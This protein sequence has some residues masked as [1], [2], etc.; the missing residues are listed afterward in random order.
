MRFNTPWA[1]LLI[2]C[3]IA[4]VSSVYGQ[5]APTTDTSRSGNT[6]IVTNVTPPLTS[7]P[8]AFSFTFRIPDDANVIQ[9]AW[10]YTADGFD[11]FSPVSPVFFEF[12]GPALPQSGGL[13][14]QL[15]Y[16]PE[17]MT[18]IRVSFGMYSTAPAGSVT[19]FMNRVYLRDVGPNL[20]TSPFK[21][22]TAL[23]DFWKFECTD[24]TAPLNTAF[25]KI[26]L[27]LYSYSRP[28]DIATYGGKT[29]QPTDYPTPISTV[30][31]FKIGNTF[32]PKEVSTAKRHPTVFRRMSG[33]WGDHI[34]YN[35]NNGKLFG[36]KLST[37]YNFYNAPGGQ[38][39]LP[40]YPEF[41]ALSET[42]FVVRYADLLNWQFWHLPTIGLGLST[43]VDMHLFAENV[44]GNKRTTW[45]G[46]VNYSTGQK[47]CTWTILEDVRG[48]LHG[49]TSG[50]HQVR[51]FFRIPSSLT[52]GGITA[53]YNVYYPMFFEN[54]PRATDNDYTPTPQNA[55]YFFNNVQLTPYAKFVRFSGDQALPYCNKYDGNLSCTSPN[56]DWATSRSTF[57]LLKQCKELNAGYYLVEG[58]AVLRNVEG[59]TPTF[60][61]EGETP[62]DCLSAHH[63]FLDAPLY[64]AT[65]Q[66]VLYSPIYAEN[67]TRVTHYNIH[68][69]V[70]TNP[71]SDN[72]INI[73]V[74]V[75]GILGKYLNSTI[76]KPQQ[77]YAHIDVVMSWIVPDQMAPGVSLLQSHSLSSAASIKFHTSGNNAQPI[78]HPYVTVA[79]DL[80]VLYGFFDYLDLDRRPAPGDVYS[81]SLT[82]FGSDLPY[83][84]QINVNDTCAGCTCDAD[85][86][87]TLND[88]RTGCDCRENLGPIFAADGVTID[89]CEPCL[90]HRRGGRGQCNWDGDAFLPYRCDC[91]AAATLGAFT[92]FDGLLCDRPQNC[93]KICSAKKNLIH[94]AQFEEGECPTTCQCIEGFVPPP[95]TSQ[96]TECVCRKELQTRL[97]A[98]QFYT[99]NG[100]NFNE[101]IPPSAFFTL[102]GDDAVLCHPN[103][104]HAVS[105]SAALCHITE[106]NAPA[107]GLVEES[108]FASRPTARQQQCVCRRG[109]AGRFCEYST[110]MASYSLL[111]NSGFVPN[112]DGNVPIDIIHEIS[113]T[114]GGNAFISLYAWL[115]GNSTIVLEVWA[116]TVMMQML[117]TA[118]QR[119]EQRL[120]HVK[121]LS[122]T[123]PGDDGDDENNNNT[124]MTPQQAGSLSDLWQAWTD[125]QQTNQNEQN[126]GT[127]GYANNDFEDPYC[128]YY[129]PRP[130]YCDSSTPIP[131]SN[132]ESYDAGK[133]RDDE[134]RGLFDTDSK[135][136][137]A[138]KLGMVAIILIAALGGAALLFILLIVAI[139]CCRKHEKMCFKKRQK[140]TK[141]SSK[142]PPPSGTEAEMSSNVISLRATVTPNNSSNSTDLQKQS[143]S[144]SIMPSLNQNA[145]PTTTSA[146]NTNEKPLPPGWQLQKD[147]SSGKEYYLNMDSLQSQWHR[148]G[149]E[150]DGNENGW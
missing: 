133:T 112:I 6:L 68:K 126:Q 13:D 92:T 114:W 33:N 47:V 38:E 34:A 79:L 20:S 102:S 150:I 57:G 130:A 42:H 141:T 9:R 87:F 32:Y 110:A 19:S 28:A 59:A 25:D 119:V 51:F 146:T 72:V 97:F 4:L 115:P 121:L 17:A 50:D 27:R 80:N 132:D 107:P 106:P 31:V 35:S 98:E 101:T 75:E 109:F 7:T 49:I 117:S 144:P 76:L 134:V 71:L 125:A 18:Q 104:T 89:S 149:E 77:Q 8:N 61:G 81:I 108:L 122:L 62:Q 37:P 74:A 93:P 147:P 2:A 99:K 82:A 11:P 14:C 83:K 78:N 137:T 70:E 123:T 85:A 69:L 24:Y 21:T 44:Q 84:F 142:Q 29:D 136:N 100:Y 128:P 1:I 120:P 94:S 127:T 95:N 39:T 135:D 105:Y 64:D 139:L 96:Q 26:T 103:N 88:D 118:A 15:S 113:Q 73:K 131:V 23:G 58:G 56:S 145:A 140:K 66:N 60:F 116:G 86:G 54:A 129:S 45:G 16:Y 12:G 124:I 55:P 3:V 67:T 65:N 91:P 111:P 53:S 5:T 46:K 90:C 143:L 41:A 148:P 40:Q 138:A 36:K 48:L 10:P 43:G 30:V 52:V 63:S 22:A